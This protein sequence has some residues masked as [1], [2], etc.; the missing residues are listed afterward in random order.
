MSSLLSTYS[1]FYYGYVVDDSNYILNFDEGGPELVANL[2]G[3]EYT[4]TD[5]ATEIQRALND[6]GA[7][8]YTVTANRSTRTLTVSA[9]GTFSLLVSTGTSVGVSPFDLMGFTGADRTGATSYTG[10]SQSG[11]EYRPQFKLQAYISTDHWQQAADASINKT[12]SGRVEIVKFG[13]EK[14]C[15]FQ[16]KWITES[17]QDC[18]SPIRNDQLALTNVELFLQYLITRSPFEFMPDENTPATFQVLILESSSADSKG[19]GYKLKE[20]YDKDLPGFFETDV[21]KFRLVEA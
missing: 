11:S 10:D 5:F 8:T 1:K 6:A 14:F 3:G 15:Q 12:A 13:T 2:N 21:L 17:E 9:T 16:I 4:F 7:L 18:Q 19:T 20:L